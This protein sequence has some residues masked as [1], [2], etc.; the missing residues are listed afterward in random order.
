MKKFLVLATVAATLS[1]ISALGQGY[2]LVGLN[3]GSV[4]TA[5]GAASTRGPAIYDVAI[6]WGSGTPSVDTAM[7]TASIATNHAGT[8]DGT[9]A[10]NAILND[11]RYQLMYNNNNS[12]LVS[13]LTGA[14]GNF[15]Y[16]VSSFPV[17]GTLSAGGST[18]LY[19]IAWLAA[20]G[21]TPSIAAGNGSPVGWSAPFSYAYT[22]SI[23]TPPTL[24][25]S[26]F[27]Q[28]GVAQVPEPT[29]MAL[30][31]LGGLSLLLFRRRQ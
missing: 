30:I 18:T 14:N 29:T 2:F 12:L 28:F 1:G 31:G 5:N 7:G 26:G 23:G 8:I 22:A 17:T 21:A 25:A 11:G 20:D 24:L 27:V 10:W 16:S 9:A 3:P 4:W 13:G 6:Y 15:S 19:L